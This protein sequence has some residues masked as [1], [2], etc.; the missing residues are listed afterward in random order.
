MNG[1]D[2]TDEQKHLVQE[3]IKDIEQKLPT[4]FGKTVP[5]QPIVTLDPSYSCQMTEVIR[6]HF[7]EKG[8]DIP[9]AAADN[10]GWTLAFRGRYRPLS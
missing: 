2:L 8:W 6:E 9:R 3:N 5:Y 4:G 1:I 10:A 7:R